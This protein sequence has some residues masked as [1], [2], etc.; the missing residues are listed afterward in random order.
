MKGFVDGSFVILDTEFD[1][2]HTEDLATVKDVVKFLTDSYGCQESELPKI[3]HESGS[4]IFQVVG[5][6]LVLL[7]LI[8]PSG[9]WKLEPASA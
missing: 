1:S 4:M 3:H 7:E 9:T 6:S 5:N 2:F 8:P